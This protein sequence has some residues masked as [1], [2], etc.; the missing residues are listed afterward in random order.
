MFFVLKKWCRWPAAFVGGLAY[1]FGPYMVTQGQTH[2]NLA[3]VP[4]PPLIVWCL[5]ELLFE[6]K[7]R[8]VRMGV[9]LGLLAGAQVL[10]SPELLAL[11]V[12]IVALRV[13][14]DSR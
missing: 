1:G 6:Q 14:R 5:Y 4:L 11:L 3:F 13:S 9:L 10:I 2:L 8:P 12:L 7:R